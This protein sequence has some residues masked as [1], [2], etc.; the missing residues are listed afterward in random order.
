MYHELRKRGTSLVP[1][2]RSSHESLPPVFANFGIGTLAALTDGT[3]QMGLLK[4]ITRARWMQI[5][6]GVTAAEYLR[7]V[8]KTS[9]FVV[10]PADIYER[11]AG[12]LPVIFAF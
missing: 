6:I 2:T 1:R 11:L 7:L 5:A 8:F 10:E 9:R 12:E 3:G 4:R